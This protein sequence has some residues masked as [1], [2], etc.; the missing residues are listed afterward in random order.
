MPGDAAPGDGAPS[1]AE[2]K[3]VR[4]EAAKLW[5]DTA[6]RLA[7]VEQALEKAQPQDPAAGGV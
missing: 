2:L 6:D 7:R 3:A 1:A 5:P 4:L